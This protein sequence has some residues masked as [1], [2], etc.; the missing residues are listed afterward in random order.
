MDF[1]SFTTPVPDNGYRW[2]YLDAISD[3][4]Q[5]AITVIV[6]IGSVFSPYY[7]RARKRGA[8]RASEHC[9]VNV[10]LYG[11]PWRWCMTERNES[12]VITS[13]HRL[14]IGKSCISLEQDCLRVFVDE[15]AVP[16]PS[17]VSGELRI[18]LPDYSLERHP[19]DAQSAAS[20]NHFWQPIAP[21]APIE[22]D[23][24]RPQLKWKGSAYVDCNYGQVPLESSFQSWV[25]SRSHGS[26]KSTSVHYDVVD[27]QGN[28]TQKSLHYDADG[29][30]SK[31][32]ARYN[33]QLP[34][35]RYWRIPREIRT[36]ENSTFSGLQTL[37]DTPFYSRSRFRQ[38]VDEQVHSTVH[39][40]LYLNRFDSSWVRCLLPF[41]MP[42]NTRPVQPA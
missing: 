13:S 33:K 42:R 38:V 37:E 36:T 1:P 9:S 14:S 7:A 6:F 25:W 26:D 17:R 22:V 19:L 3:D 40:S 10:A 8:T 21:Q 34:A 30:L 28:S 29:K 41:R 32:N 5:H 31:T 27:K 23:F 18:P 16:I 24:M 2:W 12:S 15:I 39:E 11:S 4:D 20:A 35:T